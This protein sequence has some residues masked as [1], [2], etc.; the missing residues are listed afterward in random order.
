M[1]RKSTILIVGLLFLITP[2]YCFAD[3]GIM[4]VSAQARRIPFH[5]VR[6]VIKD[7]PIIWQRPDRDEGPG[8]SAV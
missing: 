6:E 7:G 4:D 2:G 1:K 8:A 5:R 3:Y